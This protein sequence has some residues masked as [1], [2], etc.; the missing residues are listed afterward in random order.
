MSEYTENYATGFSAGYRCPTDWAAH[1]EVVASADS[2]SRT[3]WLDGFKAGQDAAH[4][5]YY[6]EIA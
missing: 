2:P 6:K 1:D 3:A 5:Q 4:P